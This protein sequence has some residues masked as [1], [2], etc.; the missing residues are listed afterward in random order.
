MPE[1]QV[2]PAIEADIPL[3]VVIEHHY[4]SDHVWQMDTSQDRAAGQISTNFRRVRLPRSVPVEYPRSPRILTTDWNQRSCL[5]VALLE[6][7]AIAY[8][9]LDDKR[10][11]STTWITDL[12]V[13]SRLRRRG[14]GSALLL[15]A[16]QWAMEIGNRQIIL[17]MQP[18]NH[19]AIQLAYKLGYEFCGYNDRYYDKRGAGIFFSKTL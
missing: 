7:S 6:D 10:S 15:S 19:P 14:I 2:R 8:I 17:E 11:P 3:L 4:R 9:S 16:Q 18:K 1:I 13:A 12:V 5:L